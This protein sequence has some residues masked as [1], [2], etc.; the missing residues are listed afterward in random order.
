MGVGGELRGLGGIKG[1]L[2]MLRAYGWE[3]GVCKGREKVEGVWSWALVALGWA[4]K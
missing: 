4:K 2:R 1:V 3:G